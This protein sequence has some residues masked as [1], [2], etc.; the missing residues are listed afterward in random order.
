[1]KTFLCFFFA[2]TLACSAQLQLVEGRVFSL[3]DENAGW[4]RFTNLHIDDVIDGDMI[5]RAFTT[6][7]VS[8][9]GYMVANHYYAPT[10]VDRIWGEKLVIRNYPMVNRINPGDEIGGPIYAMRVRQD[11]MSSP[12]GSSTL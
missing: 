5:C 1:M 3:T 2:I 8:D 12:G 4:S 7:T 10:H 11:S 6:T 9:P